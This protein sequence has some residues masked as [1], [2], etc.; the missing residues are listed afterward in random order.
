ME[1]EEYAERLLEKAGYTRPPVDPADIAAVMGIL[2]FPGAPG[3]RTRSFVKDAKGFIQVNPADPPY[4]R[5]FQV[6]HE[7]YELGGFRDERACNAGASALL[8]PAPWVKGELDRHGLDLSMLARVFGVSH[9]AMAYRLA[10]LF[11]LCA[12]VVD[13]G[14]VVNRQCGGEAAAPP[15]LHP[16]ETAAVKECAEKEMDVRKAG[17]EFEAL[18]FWVPKSPDNPV[19]RIVLLTRPSAF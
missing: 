7:L 4:R 15:R 8:M 9:E 16:L 3:R 12:T 5:R 13:N 1:I 18:A 10:L 6:A 19:Q 11:G 14:H 2:V 17:E